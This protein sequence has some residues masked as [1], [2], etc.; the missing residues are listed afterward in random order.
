MRIL[1]L[2]L[3][4]IFTASGAYAVTPADCDLQ[5]T[6]LTLA[7]KSTNGNPSVLSSVR[8]GKGI[9]R[10]RRYTLSYSEGSTI[11]L[12]QS[13][14]GGTQMRLT[15][16]SLQTMPALLEINRAAGIF[17]STPFWRTY[18]GELDAAPLFQKELGTDDFQSRVEKSSQFTYDARERIASPKVKNS[19]VIGF[20]QGNPGTQ[21]RSLLTITIGIE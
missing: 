9:D 3:L 14:C 16:M 10:I 6:D 18:F 5:V 7:L 20:M 13:G 1:W 4:T 21:F 8:Y 2:A 12:E 11:M 19:A 17:K 15:I